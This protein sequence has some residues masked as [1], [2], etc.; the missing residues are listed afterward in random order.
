[1]IITVPRML[2]ASILKVASSVGAGQ[3]MKE[4]VKYAQV[5]TCLL[6]CVSLLLCV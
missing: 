1:M 6:Y 4:M 5:H 2:S 3:G